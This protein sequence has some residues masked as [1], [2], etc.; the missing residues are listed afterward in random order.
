MAT[1]SLKLS[2]A[3]HE[4]LAAAAARAGRSKSAVIREALERHLDGTDPATTGSVY[5]LVSDLIGSFE[6][7]RDLSTNPRH[8]KGLGE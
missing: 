2:D 7:P 5:E 8:L 3:L 1:V 4:R 6:G